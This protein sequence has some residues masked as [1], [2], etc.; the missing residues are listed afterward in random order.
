ML[1]LYFLFFVFLLVVFVRLF[2]FEP[3]QIAS[4]SMCPTI[5]S[6]DFVL[7]NKFTYGL[8]FPLINIKKLNIVK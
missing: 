7:V 5:I 6:G 4:S 2:I 3:F 8:R 1:D